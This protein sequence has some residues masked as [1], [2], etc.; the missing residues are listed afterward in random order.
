MPVSQTSAMTNLY[1]SFHETTRPVSNPYLPK[2]P[3]G[4]KNQLRDFVTDASTDEPFQ[5]LKTRTT[6]Q[7]VDSRDR[8]RSLYPRQNSY[9]IQLQKQYKNV[10]RIKMISSEFPNTEQLIR[11]SP[12]S[13]QNNKI[14]WINEN[15]NTV[16][17]AS[18][19]SG[20]YTPSKLQ[21]AIQEA[22]NKI[23]IPGSENYH[24]F[25]V[26][27]DTVSD[28]CTFSSLSSIQ[29]SN[30]FSSVEGSSIITVFHE[31]HGFSSGQLI[32]ISGTTTFA[33][34]NVAILNKT[35]TIQVVDPDTYTFDLGTNVVESS[36]RQGGNTTRIGIGRNFSLLFSQP[37]TPANILGFE[38]VDTPFS[39]VQQNT[40]IDRQFTIDRCVR[41]DTL[42][43]A[44]VLA[45]QPDPI[46]EAGQQVYITETVGSEIDSLLNDPAGFIISRLTLLDRT[47]AGITE[48]ESTRTIKIPVVLDIGDQATGGFLSTRLLNRPVKLAGENYLLM[49]SSQLKSLE[50]TGPVQNIFAKI[51]LSAPPGT[52]LYNSGIGGS[53]VFDQPVPFI[54]SLDFEFRDAS[55]IL[56]DFLDSDHSFTLEIDELIQEPISGVNFNS[57]LGFRDV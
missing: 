55:N 45:D 23:R 11:D 1:R 7:N 44:I 42:F 52:I 47:N 49:C 34:I 9:K 31:N 37:G 4:K 50:N 40:T 16:L 8:D 41:I 2:K 53:V 43:T 14:I 17:V 22:M 19:P 18:I 56:Y 28:I 20:S 35:Q 12:A 54:D 27:I 46:L 3:F 15:D 57:R 21:Q 10:T 29:L 51:N 48:S 30:P 25:I 13:K 39:Y 33:G 6:K 24:E 32:T 36:S 38:P 5:Y 26:E